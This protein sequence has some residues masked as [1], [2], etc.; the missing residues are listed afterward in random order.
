MQI[1]LY[2]EDCWKRLSIDKFSPLKVAKYMSADSVDVP[3]Y[4]RSMKHISAGKEVVLANT[5][6]SYTGWWYISSDDYMKIY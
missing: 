2:I 4:L 1:G 6:H 5:L 3:K